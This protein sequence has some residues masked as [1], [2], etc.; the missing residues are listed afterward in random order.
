MDCVACKRTCPESDRFCGLCGSELGLSIPSTILKNALRDRRAVEIEITESVMDRLMKWG[1]W[2]GAVAALIVAGFAFALGLVYHDTR[3]VLDAGKAQVESAVADG[4]SNI[5][6]AAGEAARKIDAISKNA[7]DLGREES[8]LQSNLSSYKEVNGEMEKL[9]KQF[10][11]Q[12]DDLSKLDLRVHTLETVGSGPASV[13]FV[14]LGCDSSVLGKG[15]QVAYCAQG[16]PPLLFQRTSAG[17]LRSV[18]STSPNGF[19]DVST[20]PKTACTA[21]TRGTFYVEKSSPNEADRPFLCSRKSDNKY[22]WIQM[23]TVK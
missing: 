10:H 18:S 15:A 21:A 14:R 20:G 13:S 2:L 11:G 3:A 12:T 9:R 16:S 19:Q 7:D 23:A 8:Q 4:K 17:D 5:N 22:D 1:R 6:A